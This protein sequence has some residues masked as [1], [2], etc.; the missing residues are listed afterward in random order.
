MFLG[1]SKKDQKTALDIPDDQLVDRS[2]GLIPASMVIDGD[3]KFSGTLRLDGRIDG[4]VMQQ[5]GK[6]GTLILGKG[7][8]INGPVT[9]SD[10]ISD[11]T[12]NGT[13]RIAGRVELR[14]HA[15]IRGEVHY[16]SISIAEGAAI[17]GRCIQE[18]LITPEKLAASQPQPEKTE[19]DAAKADGISFL[20]KDS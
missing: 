15:H 8:V 18:E 12:I 11:G 3:I 1:R 14:S 20:R 10:L 2:H 5:E 17:D 6:K 13:L 4:K 16:K 19:E 7:A 9:V